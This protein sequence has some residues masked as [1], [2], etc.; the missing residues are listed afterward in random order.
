MTG[1]GRNPFAGFVFYLLILG[2]YA[3]LLR[4]KLVL[5]VPAKGGGDR[6]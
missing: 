6:V 2:C 4:C 5:C 3:G 1:R